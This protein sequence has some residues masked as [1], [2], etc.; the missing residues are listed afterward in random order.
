MNFGRYL[1]TFRSNIS[2]QT[3]QIDPQYGAGISFETLAETYQNTLHFIPEN[4]DMY[5]YKHEYCKSPKI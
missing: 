2:S 3:S 5:N 1:L 4:S